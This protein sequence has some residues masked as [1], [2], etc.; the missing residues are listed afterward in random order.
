MAIRGKQPQ[1]T[2]LAYIAGMIDGEG[3]VGIYRKV[4]KKPTHSV[5][6]HERVAISNSNL[7]ALNYINDFFPGV[8][9]KNI[10]YS[11]KHSPMWRLEYHVLRA[12]PI[13]EAVLPYLIIKRKQ[14]ELVLKYRKTIVLTDRTLVGQAWHPRLD[15]A[16]GE[17]RKWYYDELKRLNMRGV[18]PQRLNIVTSQVDEVIV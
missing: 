6:Y 12:H 9:A 10:R 14:A 5:R 15:E 8:F 2:D 1:P 17:R 7:E 11:D 18:Q 16:E 3:T 13:L 4:P